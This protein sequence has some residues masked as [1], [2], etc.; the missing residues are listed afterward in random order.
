[1]TNS[2]ILGSLP[3]GHEWVAFTFKDQDFDSVFT[4]ELCGMINY[5]E[6]R[7]KDAYSRMDMENHPWAKH[8]SS[9][10]RALESMNVPLDD[11]RILDAGCGRGRHSLDIAHRHPSSSI[12]GVDFSKANNEYADSTRLS[13]LPN[14]RAV[15]AHMHDRPSG[16]G[17]T[18]PLQM[19]KER[20]DEGHSH[21]SDRTDL[22]AFP[23]L[24]PLGIASIIFGIPSRTALNIDL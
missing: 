6:E 17:R 20:R 15:H 9:E 8:T 24:E 5:S 12:A 19:R 3:S 21:L 22:G 13:Q 7:L 14:T 10:I 2:W 11:M 1:M 23:T 16:G 18:L 4:K